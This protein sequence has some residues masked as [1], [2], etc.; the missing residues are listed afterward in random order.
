MADH[1]TLRILDHLVTPRHTV[2][3]L[4]RITRRSPLMNVVDL[5]SF[6]LFTD[7]DRASKLDR[8]WVLVTDG[9]EA[10]VATIKGESVIES[11]EVPDWDPSRQRALKTF[12]LDADRFRILVKIS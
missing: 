12:D 1:S 10:L 3:A 9:R 8:R 6:G 11:R 4:D 5:F 2:Y 7:A